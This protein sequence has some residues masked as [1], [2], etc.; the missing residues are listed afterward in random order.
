[1]TQLAMQRR[2][3][4]RNSLDHEK[5]REKKEK[6]SCQ[7]KKEKERNEELQKIQSWI[8]R[9]PRQN[10]SFQQTPPIPTHVP[11]EKSYATVSNFFP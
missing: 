7:K 4:K 2:Q 1:M 3:G 6:G 11:F 5:V 10:T 9:R 8:M